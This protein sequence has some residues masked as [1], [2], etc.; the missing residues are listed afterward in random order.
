MGVFYSIEV[1]FK[2]KGKYVSKVKFLDSLKLLPFPVAKIPKAFNLDLEKLDLDYDT[3]REKGYILK[4]YEIDYIKNDVRIVAQAL[5]IM[6]KEGLTKMTNASNSLYEYKKI[7][8]E[9]RFNQ[10][11]PKINKE[12]DKEIRQAYKGVFCYVNPE[13]KECD[14]ERTTD[15]DVNSMYPA[16]ML[17]DLP[18]GEGIFYDGKYIYDKEYPLYIQE[19]YCSFKIKK[20][21]I[22][23]IQIKDDLRYN[24]NEYLTSSNG[25]IIPLVLTSVDLKLFLDHYDISEETYTKGI[26]FRS[27]NMLFKEFVDKWIEVK[28]KSRKEGNV[29]MTTIAKTILNSL[30][31]KFA[32]SQEL[33]VKI[34]YLGED[35][36]VH[37]KYSEIQEKEGIYL[38]VACFITSLGREEVIRTSQKVVDYS[39]EKYG[40]NLYFYSDTDSLKCGLSIDE[41]KRFCNI[42]DLKLGAWKHE[43]VNP[44]NPK[45]SSI[46]A[47]FVRQ[48]TYLEELIVYDEDEDK[49]KSEVK[50]TCAGM[51]KDCYKYVE[52]EKFKEGFTCGGK[53]R[54]VRLKGGIKLIETNF[55]I[56]NS[57]RKRELNLF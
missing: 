11:F 49:Y 57:D 23:T 52:W 18:Y 10:Y 31:G 41:L 53:L 36:L 4:D 5:E 19:I 20:N 48:K 25:E 45:Y 24:E 30:Y 56:K 21:K 51:P 27:S 47:R 50:I 13:I 29:P 55:T 8:G 38:P 12:I 44:L 33:I 54:V 22:P 39:I 9:K 2:V 17:E 32:T 14:V 34:P 42:D 28:N 6:F 40:K 7:I 16:K 37:Y 3:P 35:D 46:K 1:Y 43:N 26:K 15:L